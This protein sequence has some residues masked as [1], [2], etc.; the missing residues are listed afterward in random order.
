MSQR[1]VLELAIVGFGRMG[2]ALEQIA[3][4]RGHAVRARIDPRG[5]DG[6]TATEVD[7][8]ALAGVD[9]ALEFT[10]PEAAANNVR[11]LLDLG[12]PVVSGTTGWNDALED[13]RRLARERGVGFVWAPNYALGVQALFR[14]VRHA[15]RL[16]GAFGEFAPYLVEEHHAGKKDAPSGT[17]RRLADLLVEATPDRS[18]WGPAPEHEA[19]AP[20]MLP[21]AWIRAGAIPGTHRCGWDGAGESLE[22]S[23]RV[24]DRE[25]FAAGAITV[26]EWLAGRPDVCTFEELVDRHL[27][28]DTLGDT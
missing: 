15:A 18:R 27:G 22:I 8:A 10:T 26:A 28:F 21:V 3:V 5:G 17:S 11:R 16:L 1:Q 2:R 7:P 12:V 13:A 14:I 25:V 24:R 4:R 23:H 20:D 9:V 19:I 6:V